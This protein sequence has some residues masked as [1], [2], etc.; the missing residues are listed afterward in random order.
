MGPLCG[1]TGQVSWWNLGGNALAHRLSL[2]SGSC[3]TTPFGVTVLP[4]MGTISG[5]VAVS[6]GPGGG[7]S[8]RWPEPGEGNPGTA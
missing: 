7:V 3:I 4:V 2:P 5:H 1:I 6:R 8:E